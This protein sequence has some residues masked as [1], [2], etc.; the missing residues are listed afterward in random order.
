MSIIC[1]CKKK[2][3]CPVNIHTVISGSFVR[4]SRWLS[5]KFL[6]AALRHISI[7]AP[8]QPA[9]ARNGC[10]PGSTFGGGAQ[11]SWSGRPSSSPPPVKSQAQA[12]GVSHL[13]E[14]SQPMISG[15]RANRFPPPCW[16]GRRPL[17][18]SRVLDV[19]HQQPARSPP[20]SVPLLSWTAKAP[21]GTKPNGASGKYS[22]S[23]LLSLEKASFLFQLFPV[24]SGR[25]P[26]LRRRHRSGSSGDCSSLKRAAS[27]DKLAKP[28][29]HGGH[30]RPCGAAGGGPKRRPYR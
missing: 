30:F 18:S 6:C 22:F 14:N 16:L 3:R 10:Y 27:Q 5:N 17:E 20:R 4:N 1:L 11:A 19:Q 2:N 25:I 8:H 28:H 15:S 13:C 24:F 23:C 7:V 9:A 26:A 29:E 21:F 12:Y